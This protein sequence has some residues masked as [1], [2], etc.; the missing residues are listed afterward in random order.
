VLFTNFALESKVS[1]NDVTR[2]QVTS[3]K[4]T[5]TG[6]RL[7]YFIAESGAWQFP[8]NYLRRQ[9]VWATSFSQPSVMRTS[10]RR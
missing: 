3:N 6:Y 8:Q 1:C 7:P 9:A 2:D 4:P 5:W 10:F